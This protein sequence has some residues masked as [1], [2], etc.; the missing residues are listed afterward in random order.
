[1][2]ILMIMKTIL[3][4]CIVSDNKS[5]LQIIIASYLRFMV[6]LQSLTDVGKWEGI[7]NRSSP[8]NA[9]FIKCEKKLYLVR[10]LPDSLKIESPQ[11]ISIFISTNQEMHLCKLHCNISQEIEKFLLITNWRKKW[12]S[13]LPK[14]SDRNIPY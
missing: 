5:I 10:C 4:K 14:S 12:P 8:S 1:M 6:F 11:Y 2:I 13:Y 3:V 9:L 7:C